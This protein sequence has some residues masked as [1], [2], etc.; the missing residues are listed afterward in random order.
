MLFREPGSHMSGIKAT[1]IL[2][3]V[4]QLTGCATLGGLAAAEA[5]PAV[6][7]GVG[8]LLSGLFNPPVP[9][10]AKSPHINVNA[11][12]GATVRVYTS[13]R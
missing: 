11:A 4:P 12:P 5:V 2:L 3:M 13:V 7:S 1:L 9:S 10:A 6:A 8:G